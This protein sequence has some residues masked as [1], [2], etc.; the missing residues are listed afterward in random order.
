MPLI[1]TSVSMKRAVNIAKEKLQK[2]GHTLVPFKISE[3]ENIMLK[4]I[5]T[6]GCAL[7]CFG[8][9]NDM[10]KRTY[11]HPI[12][13]YTLMFFFYNLPRVLQFVVKNLVGLLASKRLAMGMSCLKDYQRDEID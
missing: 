7:G 5:H 9:F 12:S 4:M 1:P 3:E 8:Q 10:F 6:S 13:V 2:Q 11:E